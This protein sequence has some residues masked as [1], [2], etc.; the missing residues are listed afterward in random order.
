MEAR[1]ARPAK[2]GGPR[3]PAQESPPGAGLVV[4]DASALLALLLG[5]PGANEVAEAIAG[6]ATLSTVNLSEAADALLRNSIDPE[7]VLSRVCEQVTVEPF[8]DDDAFAAA[9]LR[10]PTSALGLSLGDRACLALAQRLDAVAATAD[11][12]WSKLELGIA[13]RLV[14]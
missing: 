7:P 6:G 12:Q 2:P 11:R 8:T 14:G 13:I 1:R 10:R 9:A 5:E 3:S 4:L